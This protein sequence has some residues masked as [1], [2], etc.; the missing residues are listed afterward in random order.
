ML[1]VNFM[2]RRLLSLSL[3]A[4]SLF[5][6]VQAKAAPLYDFIANWTPL[7][8]GGFSFS[9]TFEDVD[10][11]RLFS[12][13]ELRSYNSTLPRTF[14]SGVPAIPTYTDGLSAA[15]RFSDLLNEFPDQDIPDG[16]LWTYSSTAR[17]ATPVVPLPASLLLLLSGAMSL[18]L[19]RRAARTA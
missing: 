18:H 14:L 7:D 11:D 8:G 10:G 19:L 5:I 6:G 12:L 4:L 15:W 17:P 2:I 16:P 13:D 1:T 9:A 3:F